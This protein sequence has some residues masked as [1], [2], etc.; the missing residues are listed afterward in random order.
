MPTTPE[1]EGVPSTPRLQR[2]PRAVALTVLPLALFAGTAVASAA[3][4]ADSAAPQVTSASKAVFVL[5]ADSGKFG[6]P[7]AGSRSASASAA[8]A[9]KLT[10][11]ASYNGKATD[12]QILSAGKQK[13]IADTTLASSPNKNE[14]AAW[15]ASSKFVD[16]SWPD[17]GA[18]HYAVYRDGVKIADTAAHSLRDSGVTAGSEADYK[19]TGVVDGLGH[20]W[21][22]SA[23]VPAKDDAATLASTAEQIEAKAKKY[24]YTTVVWR[25]FI[26]Q[27]W[28]TVPKALSGISGCKY[29]KG[30]KYRGDN[31]GFS[32]S[33]KGPSFRA[34]VRGSVSW[35]VSKY[36]LYPKTGWTK[37]YKNNGKFVAKRKASTKKIDFKTMTRFNGKTRAVRARI[38]ATDPFCPSGGIRRAGIGVTY[39]ARLARNGDFYVSGKYRKAPDHE[40]YIYGYTSKNRHST[41]TVHQS[42]NKSL[43][44]L[45]QPACE[46]G[47]IGNSGGY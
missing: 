8:K 10:L 12:S 6:A 35:R 16:L 18:K 14:R 37:V 45:S 20:T 19:I 3:A 23:T 29:T 41:K 9:G 4:S 15:A 39:D 2:V 36:T 30:Y 46:R 34:G 1:N 27:K 28:A 32:R 13:V 5:D 17:L 31:R 44:C 40:M 38:E 43:L 22:L 24:R 25:S 21:G 33:V 47:T 26:R 11:A 42:R 7:S